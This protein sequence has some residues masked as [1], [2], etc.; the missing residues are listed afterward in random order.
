MET[1]LKN[2]WMMV[3]AFTLVPWNAHAQ[4]QCDVSESQQTLYRKMLGEAKLSQVEGQHKKAIKS[5]K[6]AYLICDAPTLLR[7]ISMSYDALKQRRLA[8]R[9]LKAYQTHASFVDKRA[10]MAAKQS[11][12]SMGMLQPKKVSSLGRAINIVP[13]G[14]VP[15]KWLPVLS[16]LDM[17]LAPQFKQK[18]SV[19]TANLSIATSPQGAW[20]LIYP[21]LDSPIAKTPSPEISL[22]VGKTYRIIVHKKGY[23]SVDKEIKVTEQSR[24]QIHLVLQPEL[25]KL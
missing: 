17:K 8:K 13:D 25:L 16:N 10:P 22:P 3:L 11:G 2:K 14:Q 24:T 5:F 20:V 7:S 12:K 21:N 1:T 18:R 15:K 19:K 6:K 23:K 4:E 9:Y